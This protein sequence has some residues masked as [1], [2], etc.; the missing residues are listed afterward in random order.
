MTTRPKVP[1]LSALGFLLLNLPIAVLAVSLIAVGATTGAGLAV[2]WVGV[3]IGVAT[4]LGWR[5]L[6]RLERRRVG[7]L[8]GTPIASPYR[9]LPR[10]G[11]LRAVFADPATWRDLRYHLLLLP[12]GAVQSVV[13]TALWSAGVWLA[14]LPVTIAWLPDDW[15]LQIWHLRV[16]AIDGWVEALPWAVLGVLILAAAVPVTRWLAARHAL[17]AA[18]LLGPAEQSRGTAEEGRAVPT[19]DSAAR[20]MATTGSLAG[21]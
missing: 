13:L 8:L 11:W 10:R 1:V 9:P 16:F 6:A 19:L 7:A 17:L 18:R 5:M 15:R 20:P 12:L 14:A 3:P 21:S 2:V 4:V